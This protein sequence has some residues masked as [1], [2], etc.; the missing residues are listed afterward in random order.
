VSLDLATPEHILDHLLDDVDLL[1]AMTAMPGASPG[2]TW[3]SR[4]QTRLVRAKPKPPLASR[5]GCL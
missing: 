3:E 5:K 1:L 2:M 4:R